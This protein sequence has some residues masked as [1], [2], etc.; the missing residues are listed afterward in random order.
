MTNKV[1]RELQ[2]L[3]ISGS[4]T[5]PLEFL[6]CYP[7][8][9]LQNDV[10]PCDAPWNIAYLQPALKATQTDYEIV[11]LNVLPVFKPFIGQ[12]NFIVL[13]IHVIFLGDNAVLLAGGQ[14]N[15]RFMAGFFALGK[16]SFSRNYSPMLWNFSNPIDF[17]IRCFYVWTNSSC[18]CG[19]YY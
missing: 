3:N 12:N 7:R 19:A 8:L 18:Y 17:A 2:F 14:L 13:P 6:G 4:L 5:Q 10:M 1:G 9:R 15:I 11:W 16:Q